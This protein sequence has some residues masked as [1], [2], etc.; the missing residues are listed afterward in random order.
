[1]LLYVPGRTEQS[2]ASHPVQAVKSFDV[3]SDCVSEVGLFAGNGPEGDLFVLLEKDV[4]SAE[5]PEKDKVNITVNLQL[6]EVGGE[7]S[8]NDET[9]KKISQ[10]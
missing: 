6:R 1:M 3:G 7:K 4:I 2:A 9:M 8:E 10:N 5:R